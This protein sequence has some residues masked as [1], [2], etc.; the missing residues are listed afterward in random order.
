VAMRQSSTLL[1]VLALSGAL[2]IS[3][4]ALA[5]RAGAGAQPEQETRQVSAMRT[6]VI[7]PLQEAQECAENDDLACARRLLDRVRAMRDLNGYELANMWN[8][9]AFLYVQEENFPQAIVAYENVL[10]HEEEIPPGLQQNTMETLGM[11]Y[12]QVERY[13]DALDMIDRF[14]A[15]TENPRAQTFELKAIIYYQMERF[16]DGIPMIHRALEIAAERGDE[17]RENWY[18]LLQ[19]FYFE[20]NDIPNL[21]ATLRTMVEMWPKRESVVTLAGIYQQEGQE[22]NGLALF[23]A[24]YEAG[25]LTRESDFITLANMLLQANIPYRAARILREGLDDGTIEGTHQNWRLLSQALQ[26]AQEHEAAIPALR[27]AASLT[28]DGELDFQLGQAFQNLARWE[29]CADAYREALRK[30]GL[31]RSDQAQV[32]QGVC[33]AEQKRWNEAEAVLVEAQRDERSRRTAQ[34]WLR[35]VRGERDREQQIAAALAR[36]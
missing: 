33:L 32:M 24:A 14:L 7:E 2:I 9:Y 23:E 29:E 17:P 22:E 19:V 30:G 13:Q 1:S 25:W 6:Q 35:F 12:F 28:S 21:I 15:V 16:R 36:R 26:M 27:Q 5:Q 34:D 4:D 10:Q 3:S 11:L 8:F 18:Q 31:R 20:L